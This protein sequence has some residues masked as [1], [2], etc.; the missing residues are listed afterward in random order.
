[1]TGS[2]RLARARL[3]KAAAGNLRAHLP[4]EKPKSFQPFAEAGLQA[5]GLHVT[6]EYNGIGRIR[7]LI[8]FRLLGK[9]EEQ[10]VRVAGHFPL[11]FRA[12][13]L[14]RPRPRAWRCNRP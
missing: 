1:M 12:P 6:P 14:M 10:Q 3:G 13:L 5:A 9:R 11:P 4:A 7:D 2:M 8:F